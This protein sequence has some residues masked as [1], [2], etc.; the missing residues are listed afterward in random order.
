[1]MEFDGKYTTAKVMTDEVEATA[2]SQITGFINHRAFTNPVAIMPDVHAGAGAVIGF[3]MELGDKL[4]PNVIG[5]DQSCGVLMTKHG[6]TALKGVDLNTLD[7]AVRQTI[8]MTNKTHKSPVIDIEKDFN[9]PRLR[10]DAIIFTYNFNERY[11]TNF[12]RPKLDINWLEKLCKRVDIDYNYAIA[13]IGTMGGGNHYIEIGVDETYHIWVSVHSGS[14]HIG[15]KTADYWQNIAI[16]HVNENKRSQRNELIR[17]IKANYPKNEWSTQIDLLPT[18]P[19]F[20]NELSYLEGID[21]YHYLID[22]IFLYHYAN[23]NRNIISQRVIKHLNVEGIEESFDTVHN[24]INYK[25]FIIRK[26]AVSAHV[27]EKFVVPFNQQDGLIICEGLG[28]SEWNYSAPHGAGRLLSRKQAKKLL[29]V[30]EHKSILESKGI[31]SSSL[32]ADE[33]RPAYKDPKV[34]KEAIKSTA[35]IIHTVRPIINFKGRK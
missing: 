4:I 6:R 12:R 19:K 20:P 31:Y 33:L 26:G 10:Y 25:D 8:P 7:R 1:M 14:R 35:K 17:N 30:E 28:N 11:G 34:I 24:Y 27:G 21:I 23:L 9:W 15:A 3:T 32:P 18:E 29:N 13:S 22:A 16:K 2:Q 5:V